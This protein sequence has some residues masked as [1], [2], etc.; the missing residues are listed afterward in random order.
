[1]RTDVSEAPTA[2]APLETG[3]VIVIIVGLL[4]G[5]LLASL[6]QTIVSTALPTIVGD[7]GGLTELSWVVTSYLLASTASTPLWGKLG[8]L[9]GRKRLF[10]LAIIIFLVGSALSGQSRNMPE[11]ITFRA[12]QGLGGGGLMVTAQAIVG[13]VV[14]PRERGKYQGIFGAVF[15]VTAIV[16]PLLG[17][18]FVDT[19]SWRWVFYINLPLGALALIV[20][21]IVLPASGSRGK[22][23][24]DYLG[25]VLV[26]A[27][28]T[29]L[30]LLTTLGGVTY[31]WFSAPI[32]LLALLAIALG[33][34]F[35]LAERL[36]T[37]PVLPPRLFRN[38]VFVLTSAIGFVVGFAMFGAITFL[39]LYLQ[40]VKGVSPTN[41]GLRLLPM[42]AGLLLTSTLSGQLITRWG[43]YKMFPIAGTAVF[44]VGLFLLSRMDEHT[45][46]LVSSINMLILGLGLGM[47]M[48]VLVIAVQNAVAYRDLGVATSGA[49]FFRSIGSSFGVAVFGAIFSGALSANL[50][51]AGI[52]PGPAGATGGD[53]AAIQHLP[54]AIRGAY[55]HAY[56]ISLQPVFLVA[57]LIGIVAFALTWLLREVPL[58]ATTTA[59]DP[60]EAYGMP[61]TRTSRQ[62]I[63]RALSILAS[64]ESR[65]R[66]F[67]RLSAKAGLS[68]AP[69]AV[70]L[71]CKFRDLGPIAP[72][73]LSARVRLPLTSLAGPLHE[74]VQ[75]GFLAPAP[76][77]RNAGNV[78][79]D[80]HTALELTPAG[81]EAHERMLAA[82]RDELDQL[83]AG[84][85][86]SQEAEMATLLS[87][88]S[89]RLLADDV[90]GSMLIENRIANRVGS[91]T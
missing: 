28:A 68:L 3:R 52:T 6:D 43:R 15:G 51:A 62:E 49:T 75:A 42:M 41:S 32:V 25:T 16:G 29:S 64:R 31:P 83:L 1:M 50:S 10:Q 24:I 54:P 57:A 71:L 11:L 59:I 81:E 90:T 21:A 12:I 66:L 33:I 69:E 37:E 85:S 30:V 80:E 48:Q 39:P 18:F 26:A 53:P 65:L 47:V 38:P 77:D 84:W 87:Q 36:A 2:D 63:R 8:D 20:T 88:M 19:L 4:L 72:E 23:K 76:Q 61:Q 67:Q 5:M 74:L 55:V 9:Y 60:G 35:V 13:D 14:S 46:T 56:A 27:A 44:T 82:Q 34:A 70:W 78:P 58:R 40:V 22:I 7:L 86:P 91:A 17:G 45:S 89:R 73:R 79:E